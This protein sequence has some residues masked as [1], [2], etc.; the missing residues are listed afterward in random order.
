M[1]KEYDF[2]KAKQNPYIKRL[3]KQITIR[4]DVDTIEYFKK[5][6]VSTGISYQNLMNL[7]LANCALNKKRINIGWE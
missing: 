3:R 1:R 4:I 2:S 6:A 5:Q 7:Y